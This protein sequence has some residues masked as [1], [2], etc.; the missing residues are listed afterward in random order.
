MPSTDPNY[1]KHGLKGKHQDIVEKLREHLPN[2]IIIGAAKSGTTSLAATL[3]RHPQV[4]MTSKP[5]EPKFFG[6]NYENG[7]EWYA[8]L[9]S[10]GN[11]ASKPA[12]GEAST[13]YTSALPRFAV[14]AKLM[15]LYLPELKLIYV[16]RH[17]LDRVVSQWRHLKGK[18]ADYTPFNEILTKK[19]PANLILGCSRY[20]ERIS[21][22]RAEF[23]DN[24]ILPV[25]FE[26]LLADPSAEIKRILSFLGVDPA[27]DI[28][29]DTGLAHENQAGAQN[30]ELVPKPTWAPE[31]KQRV[32]A[33]LQSDTAQFLKW[34]G[35]PA[36]YWELK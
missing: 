3:Q 28:L 31:F 14:T 19:N 5:K 7:W 21:A 24:Q 15:R 35:K 6:R 9:F 4:F 22:F 29:G 2:F 34:M 11:A 32:I 25:T 33:E 13:M 1:L 10:R 18:D 12:R 30:R 17:P 20:F 16:T 26:D 23:P 8:N 36:D 27:I